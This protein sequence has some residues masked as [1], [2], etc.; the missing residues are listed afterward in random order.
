MYM[1]TA[2]GSAA[3]RK[4]QHGEGVCLASGKPREQNRDRNFGFSL[5]LAS[6]LLTMK[7][8]DKPLGLTL[9]PAGFLGECY[10]INDDGLASWLQRSGGKAL[11]FR[12]TSPSHA[13]IK[14]L[15]PGT[16]P[17]NRDRLGDLSISFD[18]DYSAT[19]AAGNC[20]YF[21]DSAIHPIPR[22]H[23]IHR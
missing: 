7:L 19:L 10:R 11:G 1:Q 18:F 14:S 4:L 17:T 16:P 15:C 6:W 20:S 2:E 22:T 23:I 9:T 13:F 5:L 12:T 3:R 8:D 21:F